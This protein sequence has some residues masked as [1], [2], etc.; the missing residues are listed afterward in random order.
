[1]RAAAWTAIPSHL[2]TFKLD[3]AGV[4]PRASGKAVVGGGVDHRRRPSHRTSRAVEENE[5]AIP[6]GLHLASAEAFDLSTYRL[7]VLGQQ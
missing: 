3:L 1:M 4:D 2:L 7:V 6:G 5:K